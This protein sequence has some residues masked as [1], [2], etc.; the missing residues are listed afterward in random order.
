MKKIIKTTTTKFVLMALAIFTIASTAYAQE[1]IWDANKII[2]VK[3][4]LS[5]GV[6]AVY[7]Q[8]SLEAPAE[9][10][11]PTSGG[12]II[13]TKGVLVI[14]SFLNADLAGQVIALIAQETDLP[15]KYLVNTSYHGDHSY[16]NYVFPAN[17]IVIQHQGTAD[18]IASNFENDKQWMIGSFGKG[19][20]IEKV[21][22]R[23]ADVLIQNEDIMKINL[24]GKTVEIRTFGFGQTPGD[25]FIWEPVSKVMWTGN[26]SVSGKPGLPWLLDG[27]HMEVK[28]TM[29]RVRDFLP[30]D[31]TIIPGHHTA[32]KKSDLNFAINYLAELHNQVSKAVKDGLSLEKTVE[33]ITMDDY[34]GYPIFGWVHS[35][36]NVPNTY[37]E[38]SGKK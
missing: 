36:I 26:V 30:D 3:K 13:G 21:I 2:L 29:E 19:R 20:G 9:A 38:L 5:P 18:Y 23:K 8:E 25:L 14:E 6:F 22:S 7:P 33:K 12:F 24:G 10:P 35:Q 15:I 27:K 28:A 11:K 31:A 1:P 32:I 37:K 17:T 16:G 4:E 34:K